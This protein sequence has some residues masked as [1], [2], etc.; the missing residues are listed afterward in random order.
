MIMPRNIAR[1][2]FAPTPEEARKSIGETRGGAIYMRFHS[3][4]I[5][6][7]ETA[8]RNAPCVVVLM[9]SSVVPSN[10]NISELIQVFEQ[11]G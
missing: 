8:T 5:D 9:K 6:Y 1:K 7:S 3:N 2:K 11:P 10:F 4:N